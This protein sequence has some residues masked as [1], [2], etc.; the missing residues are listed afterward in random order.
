VAEYLRKKFNINI[1]YIDAE[2]HIFQALDDIKHNL[3]DVSLTATMVE[4]GK[5]R[6]ELPVEIETSV[7]NFR[8]LMKHI[9]YIESLGIPN[10]K[11][12]LFSLSRRPSGEVILHIKG[13]LVMPST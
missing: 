2:K 8:M 12:R 13:E 1:E 9:G 5:D 10:F 4:M 11:I 3:N 6:K 7:D